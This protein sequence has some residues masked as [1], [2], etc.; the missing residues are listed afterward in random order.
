MHTQ[1]KPWA[2]G[3]RWLCRNYNYRTTRWRTAAISSKF[4]TWATIDRLTGSD[5]RHHPKPPVVLFNTIL[6]SR[7]TLGVAFFSYF[8][9]ESNGAG[10]GNFPVFFSSTVPLLRRTFSSGT[11]RFSSHTALTTAM[12]ITL[13]RNVT[14]NGK[15]KDFTTVAEEKETDAKFFTISQLNTRITSLRQNSFW[16]LPTSDSSFQ[17]PLARIHFE[18]WMF[19]SVLHV[20]LTYFVFIT[21]KWWI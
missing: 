13:T 6:F 9:K 19:F 15:H 14:D 11:S 5:F 8:H 2:C 12:K 18:S 7:F 16:W 20:K 3:I 21:G 17:V 10:N 1:H 4:H